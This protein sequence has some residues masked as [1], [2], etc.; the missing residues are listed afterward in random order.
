MN[1]RALIFLLVSA[2]ALVVVLVAV[3][4]V[5]L[6]RE[7]LGVLGNVG[8]QRFFTDP[9]WVPTMGRFNL[10][11]MVAASLLLAGGAVLL[12]APL[13]ILSAVF[14]RFYA[15]LPMAAI[16]HR[17]VEV[18]A[19]I[20]SVIYGLWGLMAVV[21]IIAA[22]Q[23]PGASLLAGM[24]VLAIMIF[25]TATIVIGSALKSLPARTVEAAHALAMS[26]AYMVRCVVLPSIS[27]AIATGLALAA[28]R[29]I[30]ETMVVMMVTGNIVQIPGELFE[31]VRALTA[32]IALEMAY[33]LG[34]HRGALYVSSLL[35]M[36]LVTLIVLTNET[37]ASRGRHA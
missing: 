33:A 4:G 19:G 23:Q 20:P 9:G 18:L 21:P 16:G 25:P 17:V 7:S 37:F 26:R 32:N 12:A 28:A 22:W 10:V 5:F 8:W 29:A 6:F 24:L 3:I 13:A 34:D 36:L 30:G 1:D 11:P 27:G 15:P 31:P 2:T 35:L 14:L